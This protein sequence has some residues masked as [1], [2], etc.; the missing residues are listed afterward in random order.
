[1]YLKCRI[2]SDIQETYSQVEKIDWA[3]SSVTDV[4]GETY[5]IDVVKLLP[6]VGYNDKNRKE[7]YEG[8]VLLSDDYGDEAYMVRVI[9]D[10]DEAKFDL[11]FKT[12]TWERHLIDLEFS[13]LE[14]FEIIGHYNDFRN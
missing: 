11:E 9:Y 5:A 2:Y 1:M 4:D 12:D 13:D 6:Y 3:T 10:R 14:R 8:D 7:I